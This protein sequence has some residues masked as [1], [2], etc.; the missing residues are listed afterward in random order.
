MKKIPKISIENLD[1]SLSLRSI[2]ERD[3]WPE[4][5]TPSDNAFDIIKPLLK[6]IK[7]ILNYIQT[8]GLIETTNSQSLNTLLNEFDH[9]FESVL[10]FICTYIHK[11]NAF[12]RQQELTP[13]AQQK[14]QE[15]TDFIVKR[16][17]DICSV[18]LKRGT[19]FY[20]IS[21][22]YEYNIFLCID[23]YACFVH[24]H[25]WFLFINLGCNCF[26][27]QLII[28]II[29]IDMFVNTYKSM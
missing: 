24:G 18:L 29:T 16:I 15:K 11:N 26:D 20:C 7:Q 13:K 9:L 6:G 22:I 25:M 3:N 28:K 19:G 23:T 12:N 1:Y 27:K 2:F 5:L 21:G 4:L 17:S 8:T 14:Q 10:K